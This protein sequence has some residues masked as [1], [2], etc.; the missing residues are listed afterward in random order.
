MNYKIAQSENF[1]RFLNPDYIQDIALFPKVG[2]GELRITYTNKELLYIKLKDPIVENIRE[3]IKN[4]N[5]L[6]VSTSY[7]IKETV[8]RYVNVKSIVL[9]SILEHKL[10][11]DNNVK[12]DDLKHVNLAITRLQK[13]HKMDLIKSSISTS[14]HHQEYMMVVDKIKEIKEISLPTNR[15]LREIHFHSNF[16]VQSNDRVDELVGKINDVNKAKVL[17]KNL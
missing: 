4:H 7:D 2:E 16:S 10:Y 11:L 15:L 8:Y 12:I 6:E 1:I 9:V 3:M 13:K 14:E 5:F 17:M